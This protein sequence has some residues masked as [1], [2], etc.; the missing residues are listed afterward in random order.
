VILENFHPQS[1][2][3]GEYILEVILLA[4]HLGDSHLVRNVS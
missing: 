2:V 4:W 1:G 3:L